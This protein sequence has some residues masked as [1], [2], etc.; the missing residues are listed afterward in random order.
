MNLGFR[1]TCTSVSE[2]RN[3]L[4]HTSRVQSPHTQ[5]TSKQ[6]DN[7]EKCARVEVA[8]GG[9]RRDLADIVKALE[10]CWASGAAGTS[11][12]GSVDRKGLELARR[13]IRPHNPWTVVAAKRP[14]MPAAQQGLPAIHSAQ[15]GRS[16][17]EV[18]RL[19]HLW[20]RTMAGGGARQVKMGGIGERILV[21]VHAE[22]EVQ[23]PP[24]GRFMI[25][26]TPD[27]G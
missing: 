22:S 3:H 10:V 21:H 20:P 11:G 13:G 14:Q 24:R 18:V 9:E 2:S 5:K 25:N 15:M 23:E 19:L 8:K 17:P 4:V 26:A 1:V 12:A 6:A 16:D 7:A 27:G